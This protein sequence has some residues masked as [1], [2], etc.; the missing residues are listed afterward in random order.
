VVRFDREEDAPLSEEASAAVLKSTR[1][2]LH[3]AAAL[4]ISD[5]EKGVISPELLRAILPEAHARKIPVVVD[6]KPAHAA[7]YSPIT[8]IT[9]NT[10]EAAQIS[11]MRIRDE[12]EARRA[13]ESI[14]RSLGCRA[15]LMTRGDRGMLLFE[16]GAS[17]VIIPTAAREVFDVTGA[18][19]TVVAAFV[20]SLA[21][22][23][24]MREAA[25]LSNAAAGVVVGKVGTAAVSPEEVLAAVPSQ[26]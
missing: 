24:T 25:E 12:A 26:H 3:G 9:P 4:V 15:V 18:G 19:D 14:L 17:P 2:A 22:G 11:G 5:Y 21:S 13:G 10:S 23:A 8:A 6:P 16:A 7:H 20:L 1:A